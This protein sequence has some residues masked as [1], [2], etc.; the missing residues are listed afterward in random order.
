M[1]DRV[2]HT[3]LLQPAHL[4]GTLSNTEPVR[5]DYFLHNRLKTKKAYKYEQQ[6]EVDWMLVSV[7]GQGH[8]NHQRAQSRSQHHSRT[9]EGGNQISQTARMHS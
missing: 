7:H 1:L 2:E 6:V 9:G 3:V 8:Q 4:N 5:L